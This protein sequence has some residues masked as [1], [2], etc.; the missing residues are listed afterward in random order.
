MWLEGLVSS[1]QDDLSAETQEELWL[2]GVSDSQIGLYRL[3]YIGNDLPSGPAYPDDFMSWWVR[4]K[5]RVCE[6]FVFP[7]TNWLGETRGIQLRPVSR[8]RKNYMDF[9]LDR[10]EPVMFGLREAAQAVW[11]SGEVVIVEGTFDLLPLQRQVPNV[12]STLTA[13]VTSQLARSLA[14]FVGK[15]HLFYDDDKGGRDGTENFVKFYG[16][17]IDTNVW[18]YPTGVVLADGKRVKD[19]GDLWEA[20]GDEKLASY[21]KTQMRY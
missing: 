4:H 5:E 21:V 13:K 3:G 18:V 11:E 7:L 10:A 17:S 8:D 20:W 6:S 2:R 15:A 12:I 9:F 19:P 1:S 16:A 14:R